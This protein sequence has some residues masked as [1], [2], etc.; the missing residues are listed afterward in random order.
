MKTINNGMVFPKKA[1]L[2]FFTAHKNI[3][4]LKEA[5]K[6]YPQVNYQI[7]DSSVSIAK[8]LF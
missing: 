2:E 7:V 8:T 3:E 5:L 4:P 1:Y 6:H